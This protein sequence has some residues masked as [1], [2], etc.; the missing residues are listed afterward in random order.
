M[1]QREIILQQ[2]QYNHK[3]GADECN[4]K[5]K[6]VE[7]QLMHESRVCTLVRC[8]GG[9]LEY[10]TSTVNLLKNDCCKLSNAWLQHPLAVLLACRWS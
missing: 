1:L 10:C 2:Q 3:T 7:Q 6:T 5:A 8:A 9:R 4:T